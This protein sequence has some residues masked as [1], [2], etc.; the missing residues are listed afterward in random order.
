MNSELG[1]ERLFHIN[2]L[3]VKSINFSRRYVALV[4]S[5][6]STEAFWNVQKLVDY[7]FFFLLLAQ[8]VV[9]FR[10]NFDQIVGWLIQGSLPHFA[11]VVNPSYCALRFGVDASVAVDSVHVYVVKAQLS[12]NAYNQVFDVWCFAVADWHG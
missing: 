12:H 10:D 1:F 6:S 8:L 9:A 3:F 11:Q 5:E 7:D 4:G 2:E